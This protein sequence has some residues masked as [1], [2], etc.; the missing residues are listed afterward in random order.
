[1]REIVLD[2]ETTGLKAT[3]GHRIVEIGAL[4]LVNH[5]PTGVQFHR[6]INPEREIDEGAYRVHGLARDFLS[7][8]GTFQDMVPEFLEFIAMDPLIIHN[9][10]FDMGFINNELDLAGLPRISDNRVID[11]LQIARTR[12]PGAQASLDALCRRFGIDNRHR[13]LHG[14]L[15]DAD[16]LASVYLELV[17]GREPGLTFGDPHNDVVDVV[18]ETSRIREP[19]TFAPTPEEDA[20]H[21]ALIDQRVVDPIWRW[22]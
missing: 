12:F 5:M 8:H 3:E 20:A 4:E 2:T 1:M 6:Y 7:E 18:F 14:A 16:L 21:A 17:G 10:S 11:T 13:D 9:A 19:R 15:V 22:R